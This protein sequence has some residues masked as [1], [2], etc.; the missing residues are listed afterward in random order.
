[1]CFFFNFYRL[2]FELYMIFSK[3][4]ALEA[5]AASDIL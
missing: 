5:E 3:K 2:D 4:P 1:M